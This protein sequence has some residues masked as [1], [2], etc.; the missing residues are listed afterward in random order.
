MKLKHRCRHPLI[1]VER[2][3]QGISWDSGNAGEE[4]P[5]TGGDVADGV[6]ST[7]VAAGVDVVELSLPTW[8]HLWHRVDGPHS[9]AS[10]GRSPSECIHQLKLRLRRTSQ[11][12]SS[13]SQRLQKA[14]TRSWARRPSRLQVHRCGFIRGSLQTR[15]AAARTSWWRE[16]SRLT[17][18]PPSFCFSPRDWEHRR[19]CSSALHYSFSKLLP[20]QQNDFCICFMESVIIDVLNWCWSNQWLIYFLVFLLLQFKCQILSVS[21]AETHVLR[22]EIQHSVK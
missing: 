13:S 12:L 21:V 1:E 16:R 19:G 11:F 10:L 3:L 17:S 22:S 14:E 15:E 9:S 8:E 7:L 4:S 5:I 6:N 20:R 18:T 2:I